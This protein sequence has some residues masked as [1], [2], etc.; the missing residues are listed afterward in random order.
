MFA[1]V[2]TYQ[3]ETEQLVEGFR[4]TPE[5]AAANAGPVVRSVETVAARA[6]GGGVIS[7][8][9]KE[10]FN[11]EGEFTAYGVYDAGFDDFGRGRVGEFNY[12]TGDE[13]H[14]RGRA[15]YQH[16]HFFAIFAGTFAHFFQACIN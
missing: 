7:P 8:N 4:R 2:S 16:Q 3:G 14:F 6:Y 5:P 15:L 10:E 9:L 11:F 12:P 13:S 1:R